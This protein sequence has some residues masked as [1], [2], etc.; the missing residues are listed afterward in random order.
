[1]DY[2]PDGAFVDFVP[3]TE[4]KA[5]VDSEDELEAAIQLS[6]QKHDEKDNISNDEESFFGRL[7]SLLSG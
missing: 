5:D 6:M 1:M 2:I 4:S 7:S 3:N